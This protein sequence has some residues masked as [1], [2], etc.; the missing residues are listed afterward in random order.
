MTPTPQ[1][2][3]N[4]TSGVVVTQNIT[5]APLERVFFEKGVRTVITVVEAKSLPPAGGESFGLGFVLSLMSAL[6]VT[7]RKL[8][9]RQRRILGRLT[10]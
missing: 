5:T 8:L 3:V 1:P 7:T 6:I 4:F 9:A 2:S 10:H